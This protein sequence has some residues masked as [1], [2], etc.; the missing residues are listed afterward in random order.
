MNILRS[1]C[2]RRPECA[3]KPS[4]IF[5]RAKAG[6]PSHN[7]QAHKAPCHPRANT[8]L[9][10]STPA[11][12]HDD[13][14]PSVV[15]DTNAALDGL[16]FDDPT[17]R[18]LMATLRVGRLRWIATPAM[19][20]E[21]EQVLGRSMLAKH[22]LDG[23]YT[24]SLFDGLVTMLPETAVTPGS[25]LRCRDADDQPFLDLALREKARWLVTSDRDLLC[26]ARRANRLGLPILTP[27]AWAGLAPQSGIA[28]ALLTQAPPA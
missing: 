25:A 22:V 20:R 3:E 6:K 4:I 1:W 14:L 12:A 7:N 16:L 18:P 26:L 8:V 21:F 24:L 28:P 13:V 15:L 23:E 2:N 9:T 19:R 10:P 5:R 11:P 17:I 27:A